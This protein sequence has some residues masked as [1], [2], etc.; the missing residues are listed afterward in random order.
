MQ[1]FSDVLKPA[2]RYQHSFH[3]ELNKKGNFIKE[4]PNLN[5]SESKRHDLRCAGDEG[6]GGDL[7]EQGH[8]RGDLQIFLQIF[9]E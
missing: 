9:S 3:S 2:A 6:A 5:L 1:C 8:I 4:K 7:A